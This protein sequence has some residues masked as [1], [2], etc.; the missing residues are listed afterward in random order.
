MPRRFL[1][2]VLVVFAVG[3]SA[4]GE[5]DPF[6]QSGLVFEEPPPDPAA[7]VIVLVAGPPS[8]EHASGEHEHLAGMV[9]LANLLRQTPGV[10]PRLV[11]DGWPKDPGVFTSA[12]CIAFFANGGGKQALAAADKRAALAPHL[13]AGVGLVHLH[14]IVDYP[15]A[16]ADT[17]VPWLGGVYVPGRSARGHW[18]ETFAVLPEHAI[19]RGVAPFTL[20]DGWFT[21]LRFA[22]AGVTP[23][24][25][26]A[27]KPTGTSGTDNVMAWAF[28]R[29][30][31]GR[32]FVMSGCHTHQ[33]WSSESLRRFVVNGLLWSARIAVPPGGA[34][35]ALPADALRWNLDRKPAK[36]GKDAT[37]R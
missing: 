34:P 37:A 28:E 21:K 17:M 26:A 25:R 6:D 20:Y 5:R 10:H 14:Q 4:A 7:A 31:G 24:L 23:L 11:R 36:T 22:P 15:A 32:S 35:V 9:V 19:T 2:V 30:D 13:A 16:L 33:D 27:G 18:A 29:P 12:K 3:V 8:A 1:L